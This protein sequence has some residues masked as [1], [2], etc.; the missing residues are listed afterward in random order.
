[1]VRIRQRWSIV[2]VGL[3]L[4]LGLVACKKDGAA[5]SEDKAGVGG[6]GGGDLAMLPGDSDVVFGVNL[7]QIQ[8]SGLWKQFV[9]P[10]LAAGKG[11]HMMEEF[12]TK[13]GADPLK[14]VSSITVGAKDVTGDKP[15]MVA[16]G[17]GLDK[18]KILD[19]LEKN[20]ADI[21]KDGSEM[22][23]DG[24]V[25]LFKDKKGDPGALMFTNDSTAVMVV[26]PNGTAAGVKAVASGGS[27]L[28]G[29]APF[30]EMY[31]K[32]KT[33]DSIWGLASGKVMDGFPIEPKPTAAY[34][35]FN[36][37]DGLALDLRF[38]FAKPEDATQAASMAQT[39]SAQ[40]K[41]FFDKA[42]F[43]GDGNE[44]H[45][46]VTMSSQKLAQLMPMLAML[47][48]GFPGMG[49]N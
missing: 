16:I 10:K 35:S 37:T 21:T 19:C 32:V 31:K 43:V 17:H 27:S 22:T 40:A 2:L 12:K 49:G 8:Q 36:V 20:K 7:G 14:M 41:Q 13:C 38:R 39:Q 9:E 29:S 46:S 4:G 6:A 26:G 1:M 24:D 45:A 11:Q 33:T 3:V 23:R 5:G 42:E 30:L 48:G 15:S 18:A 47:A 28:K 34:G 25:V 44:L